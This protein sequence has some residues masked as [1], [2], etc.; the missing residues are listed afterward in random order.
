MSDFYRMK[1]GTLG[2]RGAYD[3]RMSTFRSASEAFKK[4]SPKAKA[5]A[6]ARGEILQREREQEKTDEL[7]NLREEKKE[8]EEREL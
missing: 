5:H 8:P 3:A 2:S 6:A 7:K 1:E 4:A